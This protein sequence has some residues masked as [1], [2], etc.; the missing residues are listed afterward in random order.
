MIHG[1][2][3][4]IGSIGKV[5]RWYDWTDGCIVVTDEEIDEIWRAVP[6][7]TTIEIRP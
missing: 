4:G 7:G 5:H 3:N 2:P 1:L 6:M